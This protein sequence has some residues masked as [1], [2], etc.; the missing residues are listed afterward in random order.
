MRLLS[1]ILSIIIV[2]WTS[3][4]WIASGKRESS[5]RSWFNQTEQA[6]E[7]NFRKISTSGFPNRADITIEN[8]LMRSANHRFSISTEV[9]QILS[10]IYD[11]NH[12]MGVVKPPIDLRFNENFIQITGNPIKSSLKINTQNNFL[13]FVSES[14]SLAFSDQKKNLWTI[15]RFL[16]A[17]K[18]NIE[19][20]PE[21]YKTHLTVYQM[22]IPA[23]FSTF[24]KVKIFTNNV[25]KKVV[26][27]CD[28][29]I[30]KNSINTVEPEESIRI[31]DLNVTILWGSTNSNLKGYLEVS[32]E[33]LLAGALT[34]SL[35]N[36]KNILLDIERK[37]LFNETLY[38][39]INAAV[40]FLASQSLDKTV[41]SLPIKIENNSF[42]IGPIKIGD[43]NLN[44]SNF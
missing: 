5:V 4:W 34:F 28:V 21:T 32:N 14:K 16:L 33:G 27:E 43:I 29:Q 35:N 26:L 1:L 6:E 23:E 37:K 13:E 19:K 42:F 18:K 2:S 24:N 22:T 31:K 8:F 20:T 36:W 39:K 15:K 40:N 38:K 25:I 7:R 12:L 11:K 9:V 44:L 30:K 10:L 41:V 17:T 3:F